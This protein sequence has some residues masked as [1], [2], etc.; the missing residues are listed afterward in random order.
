MQNKIKSNKRG[1][2]LL[3]ERV[4]PDE[5]QGTQRKAELSSLRQRNEKNLMD[6]TIQVGNWTIREKEL[7]VR[8][9]EEL[10]KQAELQLGLARI[11]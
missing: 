9:A 4:V 1:G 8:Q 5:G 2:E 3:E 10:T 6:M 11:R 7:E